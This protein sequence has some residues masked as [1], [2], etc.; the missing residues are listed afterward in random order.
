MPTCSEQIRDAAWEARVRTQ[1]SLL[2]KAIKPFVIDDLRVY[3]NNRPDSEGCYWCIFRSGADV[4]L[5]LMSGG[6]RQ[7]VAICRSDLDAKTVEKHN[8]ALV[9][10]AL[11]KLLYTL[12]L[13]PEFEKA[14]ATLLEI[15]KTV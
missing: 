15:R 1:I 12:A 11:R 8:R 3:P 10:R 5:K 13:R 6:S 2:I 7:P 4:I 14:R 9:I